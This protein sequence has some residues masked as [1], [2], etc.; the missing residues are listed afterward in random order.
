[1]HDFI[2]IGDTVTD[3]FI[4]LKNAEITGTPDSPDYKISLP[5]AEKIPYEEVT[6]LPAVGNAANAAVSFARLGLNS[7]LVSNVGDDEQGKEAIAALEANSVDVQFIKINAGIKTNYH[8]VLWYG[9]ER[10]ILTKH[11]KYGYAF[12]SIGKAKWIYF[13]SISADAYPYHEFVADHLD[14]HLDTQF[15]FQPGK[16]E[17]KLGKERLSRFYKRADIFFCNM[18]EAGAILDIHTLGIQEILKRMHALGPKIVVITDGPKGAYAYDGKDMWFAPP[19]P[20]IAPPFERTGAGD[21]F[22]STTVAA[23]AQGEDLPTSLMW[24]SINSMSVVQKV[25]AQAGLLHLD[26]IKKHL[27]EAPSD[28]TPKKL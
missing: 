12:P 17:I 9:P 24:G 21:S 6:I 1:M 26:Q 20:D 11:E 3:A 8:Y 27:S 22:A 13:S 25:G 2:A 18:E 19:F 16:N 4:K 23:L 7:A 10:T 5:F 14:I 28:F 15:A